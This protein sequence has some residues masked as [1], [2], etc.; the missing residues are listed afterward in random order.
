MLQFSKNTLT[1]RE[2]LLTIQPLFQKIHSALK[3]VTPK[4]NLTKE[5]GCF[6]NLIPKDSRIMARD[7]A[8]AIGILRKV[9]SG[10][11]SVV[12]ATYYFECANREISYY[13]NLYSTLPEF[14]QDT[15]TD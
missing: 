8:N 13:I 15:I 14:S 9:C 2:E 7:F 11:V 6:I 12:D 3:S 10:E 1:L 4:T 5:I